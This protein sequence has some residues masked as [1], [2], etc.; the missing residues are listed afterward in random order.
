MDRL[1]LGEI[2]IRWNPWSLNMYQALNQ[3]EL[4]LTLQQCF[5]LVQQVT[6]I[7]LVYVYAI[8]W[9]S[10]APWFHPGPCRNTELQSS[11][12]TNAAASFSWYSV[13]SSASPPSAPSPDPE[14]SRAWRPGT[15]LRAPCSWTVLQGHTHRHA[16]IK[17]ASVWERDTERDKEIELLLFWD[18]LSLLFC[19]YSKNSPRHNPESLFM[20]VSLG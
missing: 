7:H 16:E 17:W 10:P 11:G 20:E 5:L 15:T 12:Q 2:L 4:T 13:V 14:E 3:N 6:S 19:C 8:L 9:A 18:F 1:A